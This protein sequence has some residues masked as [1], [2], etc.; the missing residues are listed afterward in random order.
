[1]ADDPT[2]EPQDEPQ[3]P[4]APADPAPTPEPAP[5]AQPVADPPKPAPPKDTWRPPTKAE[6]DEIQAKLKASN[7]E[8][9]DRRKKLAQYERERETEQEKAIR[10]AV[11]AERKANS[12]RIIRTEAKSA[13]LSAKARPERIA[14]LTK[15][16]D[17]DKLTVNEDGDVVGLDDEVKRVAKEY[18]EFFVTDS[19]PAPAPEPERPKVPKVPGKVEAADKP[20]TVGEKIAALQGQ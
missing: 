9:A 11:E 17:T 13:L 12:P 15:L 5:Q 3:E 10:E 20:R 2:T 1:M 4:P 7:A 18:P 16:L 14:P 6:F 19:A 8:N